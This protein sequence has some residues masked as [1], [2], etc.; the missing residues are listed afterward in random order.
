ME[1]PD[2][3]ARRLQAEEALAQADEA[4]RKEKEKENIQSAFASFWNSAMHG[5]DTPLYPGLDSQVEY[6][7]IVQRLDEHFEFP[8]YIK[9]DESWDAEEFNQMVTHWQNEPN[10]STGSIPHTHNQIR[11]PW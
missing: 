6:R 7:E 5:E 3:T 8:T 1:R 9:P 10:D 2:V 11:F 4:F